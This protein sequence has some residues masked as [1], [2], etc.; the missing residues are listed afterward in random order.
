MTLETNFNLSPYFDDFE[1]SAKLKNYHK[2]LFK[3]SLAVQTRELNQLQTIL[4]NQVERFGNNIYEEGTIIDGCEFQYDANVAFVKLRD[5]DI[6]GNNIVITSF[7]NGVVQGVTSGVRA[8]VI[9]V[10]AGA[11]ATSPNFN[12]LL[13]KYIDGGTAKTNKSFDLNEQIV[14]L[15]ADGG[16]NQRANTIA[17]GAFGFG[18][19]FSIGG[20]TIFAK[21]HFIN[22]NSQ[23]IVL[24]KYSTK[25]SYKVGFKILEEVVTSATDTTLLDNASGSFN[26][27]AP[28]ADRLKLTPTLTKK[29]LF[30][31]S[32]I[33]SANT[34]SFTPIFEVENGLVKI[35]RDDTVFNSIARELAKRTYEESGNYQL[36]QINTHVKEH[37]NTGTNFGRFTAGEGGDK[38]KLA[39]G[40]EPGIA[41]VMGYRNEILA[42]E[43]IET[44]KAV[45]TN[46]EIGV[47]VTTNFGN[48]VIVDQVAGPWDPT[49]LQSVSLRDTA[50]TAISSATLGTAGAPGNEIGTAKVRGFE[51]SS[52]SGV[53]TKYRLYLFDIQMSGDPTARGFSDVKSFYVNQPSGPD[54]ICD[55]VLTNNLC[56]LEEPEFNRNIYDLGVRATKELKTLAGAVNATYEFR[57]KATISFNTGGSGTLSITGAHA[58]GTEEF[59]YGTG[60]LNDTQKREFV[61]VAGATAQT[62]SIP[63]LVKQVFGAVAN[64]QQA[65]TLVGNSTSFL[66]NLKVGDY[67]SVSN[68]SG[69][70]SITTRIVDI[71]SDTVMTTNPAIATVGD[72]TFHCLAA[73]SGAGTAEVHKIFPTGYV[74]DM[75]ENGTGGVERSITLAS[76]T[77]ATLDLKETFA[78]STNI[79]VFFNN[80]R[81]SAVG[82]TKTVRKNRFIRLDLST[83]S[84]NTVGP[85]TLGVADVFN[86]RKVYLGTTYSVNNRDVTSEF[87]IIRNTTDSLYKHSLLS[88]KEGSILS[89]ASTDKLVVE[90]DYFDHSVSS[91]IGFSSVDSYSIDPD[92]S[93]TN[94]TTIATPQIPR[95]ESTVTNRVYDLRDSIDFRPR[96]TSAGNTNVITVADSAINP[97]SNSSVD[98]DSDGSY[99]P[100]PNKT[101]T[102]DV[103]F[104]MPRID[105]VVMGKDG[106]KKVVKGIPSTKPFPPAEPAESMSLSI[107][108]VPPFPS[109]SLENSYN[110]TDP[111]TAGPRVDLAVRV[112]P[113]FHRRYT[114]QDISGIASRIDRLEYYTA[115]NVLEKSARDLSITDSNGLDRFK[116]GIFVDSFFGHNNA[117]LTDP[118]YNISIDKVK[119]EL[120]PKFDQQ[121]ID[122]TFNSTLSSN[123]T[124]KGKHTRLDVTS[125]TN[126]YQVGDVVF[127]GGAIGSATAAGTVRTVV[128]NSSIVRLYLHNANGTFTTSATLKKDGSSTTSSISSIQ[129]ATEGDLV[130]LPYS[131]NI[132]ID[133][134]WA[135]KTINPVGELSFNWVGN[136]NLFPE[137]D[138]WVDTTTQPDVQWDLDLA[139]NWQSLKDAWGTNW[140]EWSNDGD[141]VQTREV[142]GVAFVDLE[143]DERGGDFLNG[144]GAID[145]VK[146]TTTQDQVRT[147]TRLNVQTF[148]RTQK[149]GPF[150]TRTDI[151]P[152]MRS[153]IIRF[154]ATG[155]RP[156]TRVFP[157]FDNILVNDFVAPT[158]K[159]FANTSSLGGSLDT[160]ANGDVFGIFI[161]PNNNS[162][163]FRQGE[164]PFRLVDIANTATLTGTETTSAVTNY[165]SLGL[166]SSQRGITFNTREARVS[167]DTVSERRNITTSEFTG[168]QAHLDPVAQTF[169]LGDSE[170]NNLDFAD[171]RFG[172]GADGAF[173]SAIDLY[174]QRK[175]ST[176]GIAIEIREVVNGQITAIR[177]PFGYKRL[178]PADINISDTGNAP[179]PF[180]FDSPVYLRGDTEYAFVVKP[181]GSNPDYRLW[182]SELGDIDTNF[183]AIID[184]QPA[185]GMLFTS[186]ND[187][188]YTP[189]Q[190]Q[191][192]QFTIW[193]A[194]F[195]TSATGQAVYTNE[196]DEYLNATQFSS[197]R[198][199]IGEKIRGEAVILMTSNAEN[200]AVNDTLTI[201]S[202]TGKVRKLVT[203]TD[204]PTIKVD[205]KGSIP[206]GSTVTFS[207]GSSTYTGVV[208]TFT[209]NTATGF[210]QY[211]NAPTQDIVANGSSGVFTAN[212]TADD[213]FYRGQVSNASAQVFGVREFKYDVLVP[214]L[215]FAKYVDTDVIWTANT[216][217]N[218]FAMSQSQVSIEPF[219]NNEFVEGEKVIAGRTKELASL[220]GAKSLRITGAL[221]TNADRLS[222]VVDIGRTKSVIPVHNI[223]NNLN[224]GEQGNFGSAAARYIS[225]KVVLADGQEAEDLK[226]IISAYK[227]AAAE[228]DVY[229]RIQN[230]DDP[231][232]FRDKDYTKLRQVTASNTFSSIVNK[233]D[234]IEVEYGFPAANASTLGAFNNSANNNVVRY[235]NSANAHFD[236]FKYFSLKIV[237]RSSSG[238]HVVPRVKDLRAIA[239]QI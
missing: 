208:N 15:S 68:T 103:T 4:Q 121:N 47:N 105:R 61:V 109:L 128:A 228:V 41:Y 92:E 218:N 217:A 12:T 57:D 197:T 201:G 144:H 58:G 25:P 230:A 86:L 49:T 133:Q 43:F 198:F 23:T 50:A 132:F 81:E 11:E 36:K 146:V 147:G 195:N 56:V 17:S 238:S 239:L 16:E 106:K 137:A 60:A 222:P 206:N 19:V 154:A 37:L 112:K 161:I 213:G 3:P 71:A 62:A 95:F 28:G 80:K 84:A 207:T 30:D 188:T 219:E 51:Y 6:G 204:T 135:S 158:T 116:N 98:V 214:K 126:S 35:V 101:F 173:I 123:V 88:L 168:L 171:N 227:P 234:F 72:S 93:V 157:Y 63:G 2:V 100:V 184:Q 131:H 235:F 94:S 55:A 153:R 229:A 119:G 226:V 181:D 163:K 162:L 83:H 185:V 82:I 187:R 67:I 139:S 102:S 136:L 124:R 78:N 114:M 205:M 183:G 22:V 107:L 155:M 175:S 148:E 216:T 54:S 179:T 192:I 152:F 172:S 167:H 59:P 166:A 118:S 209:P 96:V 79:L 220:G 104:Y 110:F 221:T 125:N 5:K 26:E 224:T 10:A 69:Q 1:T 156:N 40:I 194:G 174:F 48:Y 24:E 178:E 225:K 127:L 231:D 199:N 7:A 138:H 151:V 233:E 113:I 129:T 111:Q 141:S 232:D 134:P 145:S 31:S 90:F 53:L 150:L 142:R 29:S 64:T 9:D 76:S 189:R 210:V 115:L 20:G 89:L 75:T 186:A 39:I 32:N 74:F 14:F 202:N 77:S 130:T 212:T 27:T 108:H 70:A 193:R 91:G 140:N 237:L 200:I 45:T 8:K 44:D 190:N 42:T 97:L 18:S 66:T 52:G 164:R 21:G 65:N 143:T 223:I 165:T 211:Y 170:F 236:T 169:R 196:N 13:V 180:Y 159:E 149:S 117:D 182:I 120:R 191:D 38:N 203:T 176:A 99:V 34:A 73:D 122:I 87:R 177:V 46:N 215:S 33:S 85:Y 160:N